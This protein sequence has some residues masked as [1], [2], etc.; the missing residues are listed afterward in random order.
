MKPMNLQHDPKFD[1]GMVALFINDNGWVGTNNGWPHSGQPA[2][3]PED[4][5][6][7]LSFVWQLADFIGPEKILGMIPNPDGV[8]NEAWFK[9]WLGK[10]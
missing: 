6:L 7:A 3:Y 1:K 5:A 2:L 4:Q 8:K 9:K 10:S